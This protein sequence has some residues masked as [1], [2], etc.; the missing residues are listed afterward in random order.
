MRVHVVGDRRVFQVGS[1]ARVGGELRNPHSDE[2]AYEVGNE[3]PAGN[4][5][6]CIVHY[7]LAVHLQ[8]RTLAAWRQYDGQISSEV[9][10]D[11]AVL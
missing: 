2:P 3:A 11:K 10:V 7:K 4:G 8:L 5:A 6:L 9:D 1:E